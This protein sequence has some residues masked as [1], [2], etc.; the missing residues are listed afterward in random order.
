VRLNATGPI[1]SQPEFQA[2]LAIEERNL[3]DDA[4]PFRFYPV[5]SFGLAIGF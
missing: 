2:N 4:R 1:A 3:E 5:L